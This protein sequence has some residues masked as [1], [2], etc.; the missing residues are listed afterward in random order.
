MLRVLEDAGLTVWDLGARLE[1]GHQDITGRLFFHRC[2]PQFLK[3]PC[4]LTGRSCITCM[5]AGPQI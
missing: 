1:E 5:Q 4:T 2:I 3:I